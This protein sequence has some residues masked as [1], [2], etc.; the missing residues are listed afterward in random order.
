[1][2]LLPHC[3]PDSLPRLLA[4]LWR[5][6]RPHLD[7]SGWASPVLQYLRTAFKPAAGSTVAPPAVCRQIVQDAIG[8]NLV[9]KWIRQ[10][11]PAGGLPE[12]SRSQLFR[13]IVTS[14]PD[15]LKRLLP[16]E[17]VFLSS[18]ARHAP[19]D[20]AAMPPGT[21][22]PAEAPLPFLQRLVSQLWKD[23]CRVP[24]VWQQI[25]RWVA[26]LPVSDR[27]WMELYIKLTINTTSKPGAPDKDLPAQP[28]LAKTVLD[29]PWPGWV[30]CIALATRTKQWPAQGVYQ[31]ALLNGLT[32][33]VL[34][35][36]QI[37][38]VR[39][40]RDTW[41]QKYPTIRWDAVFGGQAALGP[42]KR[43]CTSPQ[44]F[45][46]LQPWVASI[47]EIVLTAI[48][49]PTAKKADLVKC[50]RSLGRALHGKVGPNSPIETWSSPAN[51]KLDGLL[52][53]IFGEDEQC[54]LNEEMMSGLVVTINEKNK[55]RRRE[56][57]KALLD[58]L[59]QLRTMAGDAAKAHDA[60]LQRRQ[61]AVLA[62]INR[63]GFETHRND[64][65][66]YTWEVLDKEQAVSLLL[67]EEVNCCLKPSGK[68]AD[69]MVERLAGPWVLLV[70]KD[71]KGGVVGVGWCLPCIAPNGDLV[72]ACEFMDLKVRLSE[73]VAVTRPFGGEVRLGSVL[74][75]Q[76]QATL[77]A[78]VTWLPRLGHT[79]GFRSTYLGALHYGR[80]DG[81]QTPDTWQW[82]QLALRPIEPL[83]LGKPYYT[84]N[85]G[86][87]DERSGQLRND[88]VLLS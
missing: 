31:E 22:V 66:V 42:G 88:W 77:D 43:F 39:Q 50:L 32:R 24:A 27:R 13:L 62:F 55:A 70:A 54:M 81:W 36:E 14:G 1:M 19:Q 44:L 48:A 15:V 8:D 21:L 28:V 2:L 26:Q 20:W 73:Q 56:L 86:Q 12:Q 46:V 68:M 9:A 87:V 74:C 5:D 79:L 61:E 49:Q 40:Q 23:Q 83:F 85:V 76:G 82:Q 34:G 37:V 69:R 41:R 67:G 29:K 11:V 57:T 80:C 45:A 16:G 47:R 51:G 17:V 10:N 72:L 78:L 63:D 75:T 18:I 71:R 58:S 35:F 65:H 7:Q 53:L 64:F 30:E 6:A 33:G 38:G 3:H 84:D 52:K 4:D 60:Q 59:E 25:Q